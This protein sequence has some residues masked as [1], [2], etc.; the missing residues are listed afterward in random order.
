MASPLFNNTLTVLSVW[1]TTARSGLE[2][3]FKSPEAIATGPLPTPD[4]IGEPVAS[5]NVPSP[6][7]KRIVTLLVA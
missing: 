6:L 3:P 5:V 1:F 2:S 4:E 7:P